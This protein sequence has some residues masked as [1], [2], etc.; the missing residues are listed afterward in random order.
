M[1][2]ELSIPLTLSEIAYA[3][4]GALIGCDTTVSHITTDSRECE[5]GDLFFALRGESHDGGAYAEDVIARG[6]SVISSRRS[7]AQI[8]CDD[9]S[10]ALLALASY[11]KRRLPV[12]KHTVAITGSVGKST[13]KEITAGLLSNKY[14]TH[15]TKNNHN[16]SI[17]MSLSIL[18][19]PRETEALV[20]EMGM[21]HSG[22]I[23]ALTK[24]AEPDVAVITNIG[25]AHIGNLGTRE[26]IARAK[27]EICDSN[28]KHIIIPYDEPL[29][30]GRGTLTFSRES[31]SADVALIERSENGQIYEHVAHLRSA[32]QNLVFKTDARHIAHCAAAALSA[33]MCCGID[34]CDMRGFSYY[35]NQNTWQNIK[36]ISHISIIEDYYNAS[37]ESFISGFEYSTS[38]KIYSKRSALI[39]DILELGDSAEE[40]HRMVGFSA[41]S[42]G[43]SKIFAFGKFSEYVKSGAVEAGFCADNIFVN[44]DLSAPQITAEQIIRHAD[45]GEL[46]YAKASRGTRLERV[47][48]AI[49]MISR[50]E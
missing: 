27:L 31:P 23:S 13:T 8:V 15:K 29:L 30:Q 25:T 43:Y 35:F 48:D 38:L 26:N 41:A 16:N 37:Y 14:K 21:N 33:A 32:S 24:A 2:I 34:M 1:R 50:R 5:A 49:E 11:Y 45:D 28:P 4:H 20:L 46:I 22:E 40:I 17:G 42:F 39:G 44:S 3:C 7:N 18:S 9:A 47:T 12:L 36:Q 6:A 10:S 19:A